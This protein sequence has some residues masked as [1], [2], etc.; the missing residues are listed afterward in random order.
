MFKLRYNLSRGKNFKKWKLTA[1][2]NSVKFLDPLKVDILLLNCVLYN[3]K[4]I[5]E[6]IFYGANKNV[7]A[8]IQA[9]E[10][11]ISNKQLDTLNLKQEV[12]F[13]PRVQPYWCYAGENFDNK[14]L[15]TIL[16]KG[17]TLFFQE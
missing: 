9:E 13:N 3:N 8:W 6:K 1:P 16:T 12:T 7:C 2:D 14:K 17:N 4:K 5:A 10:V 15:S 11:L